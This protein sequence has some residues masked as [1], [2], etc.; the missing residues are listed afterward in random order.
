M[1][2][3]LIILKLIVFESK[4]ESHRVGEYSFNI[5]NPKRELVSTLNKN[6]YKSIWKG[7]M[8]L[9]KN[10]QEHEQAVYRR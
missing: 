10:E 8:I 3:K 6:F 2:C 9:Y 5:Y 7:Q 1:I 4:K